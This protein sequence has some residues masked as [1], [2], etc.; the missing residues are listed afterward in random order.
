MR[1]LPRQGRDVAG[2]RPA[3]MGATAARRLRVLRAEAHQA[4]VGWRARG[5]R[6]LRGVQQRP[7]ESARQG[8]QSHPPRVGRGVD[9]VGRRGRERPRQVVR[10]GRVQQPPRRPGD[11]ALGNEPGFPPSRPAGGWLAW[12]RRAPRLRAAV[13][14]FAEFPSTMRKPRPHASTSIRASR[15]QSG[16]H[17]TRPGLHLGSYRVS[18]GRPANELD[19]KADHRWRR[20]PARTRARYL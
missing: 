16:R 6:R 3:E 12:P 19:R 8:G 4:P 11:G 20:L 7:A 10:Q 9:D 18:V 1:L 15:D 14:Q 5:H 13:P 17:G 2:A